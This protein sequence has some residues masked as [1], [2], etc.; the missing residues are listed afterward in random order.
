MGRRVGERQGR[1]VAA[2]ELHAEQHIDGI[3]KIIGQVDNG[4]VVHH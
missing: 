2:T 4:R 3:R 1:I